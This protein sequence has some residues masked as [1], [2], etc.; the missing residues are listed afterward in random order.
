MNT[1][2]RLTALTIALSALLWAPA[3]A[4]DE[5]DH[6]A[7][8]E[9]GHETHDEHEGELVRLTDEEL[10]EFE[11]KVS[12]AGPAKVET[13]ASLPG[14]VQPNADRLAH[15]VPRYPGIVLE[16]RANIGDYVEKNQVLALIESDESLA[17]FELKTLLS[18]TVIAKHI[19]L[20]EAVSRDRDTF[21]VADLGTVWVD[22]SVYQRDIGRVKVGQKALIYIGHDLTEDSETIS[23]V[24][25]IVDERTRTAT[26]RVVLSNR[27]G[28]WRPGMFVTGKV[29]VESAEVP[30]AVPHTALHTIDEQTVVF[31]QTDEGF[32]PRPV[33]L[34]R[35]GEAHVEILAGLSA[36][37]PY[38]SR[39]GFTLK[40]ELGK[41]AFGEGHA[42]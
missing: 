11:I 33:E 25:P 4:Q 22:L 39:G 28:A 13:Y 41:E 27:D 8:E 26:A 2:R 1:L 5:H 37:E 15:I 18:G 7:H 24:T 35:T 20:G 23:Y 9:Q 30:V 21:V 6:E 40:A 38:V 19:T 17:P 34:G 31:V 36:G 12:T 10:A 3:R 42:H 32:S 16:V 14:E 29:L